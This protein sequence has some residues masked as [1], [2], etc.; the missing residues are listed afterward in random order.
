MGLRSCQ[1]HGGNYAVEG[2]EHS[3]AKVSLLPLYVYDAKVRAKI[4]QLVEEN[5][6]KRATQLASKEFGHNMRRSMVQSMG[7]ACWKHLASARLPVEPQDVVELLRKQHGHPPLSWTGLGCQVMFIQFMK[8]VVNQKTAMACTLDIVKE[9]QPSL[10]K[11]H[12]GSL[13]LISLDGN[14]HSWTIS[15]LERAGMVKH[16]ATKAAKKL[17]RDC[18]EKK[19]HF[20]Q[21]NST[22][23]TYNIPAELVIN[24]D[25]TL[26]RIVPV[27]RWTLEREGPKRVPILGLEDKRELTGNLGCTLSSRMLPPQLIYKGKT[28]SVV[29]PLSAFLKLGTYGIQ[30]VTG[31]PI[32][33]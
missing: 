11:E 20:L 28:E 25:E 30:R 6:L 8:V 16:K 15:L 10:L 3:S 24:V 31:A 14:G 9:H 21:I 27:D 5:G 13:D 18:C 33:Q 7:N 2:Q 23:K 17:P 22:V 4:V 12:G 32:S 19:E 29:I 1:Y 26:L